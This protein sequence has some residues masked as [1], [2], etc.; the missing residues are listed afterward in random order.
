MFCSSCGSENIESAGFC[1]HCGKS[2]GQT[3]P[4]HS[5]PRR[6]A[7]LT[8]DQQAWIES[9]K[10]NKMVATLLALLLTGAA[11]L[12]AGQTGLGFTL[13]LLDL[14]VFFPLMLFGVGFIL[15]FVVAII[16][17]ISAAKAIDRYN[18]ELYTKV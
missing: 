6:V 4:T 8:I 3:E 11:N 2:L 17:L 7:D 18:A 1:Q 13:L 5:L 12:Y 16:A 14:V 10:K 9:H 15:H